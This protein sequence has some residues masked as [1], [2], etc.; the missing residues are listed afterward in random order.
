MTTWKA[1]MS[2]TC[3][4]CGVRASLYEGE[5]VHRFYVQCS[6]QSCGIRTGKFTSAEVAVEVWERRVVTTT[7]AMDNQPLKCPFCACDASTSRY[8]FL[9]VFFREDEIACQSRL[10]GA[11]TPKLNPD[12]ARRVWDRRDGVWEKVR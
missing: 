4:C 10:C 8:S 6:N 9:F 3:P 5:G 1:T 7:E 2:G 11:I 12:R